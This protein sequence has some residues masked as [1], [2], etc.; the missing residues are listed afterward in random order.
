MGAFIDLTG[1][2][3]GKWS[4]IE[5]HEKRGSRTFWLCRCE[6]SVERSVDGSSLRG[7]LSKSCGCVQRE[8]LVKRNSIGIYKNKD[9]RLNRVWRGMLNRCQDKSNKRFEHYGE[10]VY[11]FAMNGSITTRLP[12]GV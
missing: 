12:N 3:F 2:K 7:G 1:E 9:R 8:K 4:A 5:L 10:E 11:P 6:C